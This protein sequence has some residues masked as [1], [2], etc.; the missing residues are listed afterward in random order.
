MQGQQSLVAKP[1]YDLLGH[2]EWYDLLE[3]THQGSMPP[4]QFDKQTANVVNFLAYAA[5]PYHIEQERL[6]L[7]VLVFLIF[8]FPFMYLL[9][10][11]YWIDVKK[12]K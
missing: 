5:E 7:W 4:E 11:E 6:G 8:F 10:K 3:L 12:H 1:M 9:K 2:V